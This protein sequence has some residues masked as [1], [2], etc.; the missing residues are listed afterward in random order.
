[1]RSNGSRS[2]GGLHAVPSA[3]EPDADDI[4]EIRTAFACVL[5]ESVEWR[6]EA[7]RR[8][9]ASWDANRA[10]ARAEWAQL[11]D[12][13]RAEWH[14]IQAGL[15][16]ERRECPP[17]DLPTSVPEEFVPMH[18]GQFLAADAGRMA[19]GYIVEIQLEAKRRAEAKR[20]SEAASQA[21]GM[22]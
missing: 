2:I 13:Q 21:G 10:A 14:R 3:T 6:A 17:M 8:V 19:Q 18:I 4:A 20:A 11:T 9:A 7:K 22:G 1:M 16:A 5:L 15:P 12:S